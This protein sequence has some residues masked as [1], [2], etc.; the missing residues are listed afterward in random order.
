MS[1]I[2]DTG[3]ERKLK[4]GREN[5]RLWKNMRASL[6]TTLLIGYVLCLTWTQPT[7]GAITN[8]LFGRKDVSCF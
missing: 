8:C 3:V 7:R 5:K 2:S 6:G 1:S 4:A